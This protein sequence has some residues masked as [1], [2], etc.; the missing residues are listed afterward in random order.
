VAFN[1]KTESMPDAIVMPLGESD[2]R[3]ERID[4]GN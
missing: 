2:I 3:L 1:D 4:E